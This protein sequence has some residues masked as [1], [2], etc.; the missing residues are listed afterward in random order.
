MVNLT[1]LETVVAEA[2]AKAA[3]STSWLKAIDRAAEEIVTNPYIHFENDH[4]LIK[5]A[6]S[7]KIY[8]ANGDCQCSAFTYNKGICKHRAIAR[9]LKRYYEAETAQPTPT[10]AT[11][12]QSAM[13]EA[14]AS[15]MRKP[16]PVGYERE[17]WSL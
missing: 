10:R 6:T 2:K 16:V 8:V 4:A 17:G 13:R 14:E 1:K 15:V 11:S 3:G 9:L 5:S 7:D 12:R